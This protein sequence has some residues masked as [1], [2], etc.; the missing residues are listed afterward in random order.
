MDF[1]A[2]DKRIKALEIVFNDGQG[3][4]FIYDKL[5]GLIA[6]EVSLLQDSA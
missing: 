3:A 5:C 4:N 1:E 6:D 2:M